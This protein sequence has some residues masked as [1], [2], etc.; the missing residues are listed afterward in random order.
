LAAAVHSP[1]VSRQTT[2]ELLTGKAIVRFEMLVI[3][4]VWYGSAGTRLIE[5]PSTVRP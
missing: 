4:G 3:A 1:Q 5:N 2:N